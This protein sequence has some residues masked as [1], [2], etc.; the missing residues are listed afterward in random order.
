MLF[1]ISTSRFTGHAVANSAN[2]LWLAKGS[3]GVVD[4]AAASFFADKRADV[5]VVV[6]GERLHVD[7]LFPTAYRD[8]HIHHSSRERKQVI[9]P[10]N[11]ERPDEASDGQM[12]AGGARW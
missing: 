3:N 4:A 7:S 10:G 5:V 1:Q 2:S 11:R 9:S 6:D 12:L 8:D